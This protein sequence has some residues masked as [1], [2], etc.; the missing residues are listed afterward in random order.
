MNTATIDIAS[1]FIEYIEQGLSR[2]SK[3]RG[4]L[5]VAYTILFII[6]VSEENRKTL[7]AL[8]AAYSACAMS[9]DDGKCSNNIYENVSLIRNRMMKTLDIINSVRLPSF[10]KQHMSDTVVEWDDF[11]EDCTVS[12]DK[13]FRKA[14]NT[15]ASHL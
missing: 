13:E 8:R 14:I 7:R 9:C 2:L 12:G 11:A 10:V 4:L 6:G 1:V 15:I 5:K 3:A